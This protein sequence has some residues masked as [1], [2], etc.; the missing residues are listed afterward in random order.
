M[1]MCVC[2]S[3]QMCESV[4]ADVCVCVCRCVCYVFSVAPFFLFVFLSNSGLFVLMYL[5]LLSYLFV[6]LYFSL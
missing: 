4:C 1:Q 2:L 3:M 6:S 5:L